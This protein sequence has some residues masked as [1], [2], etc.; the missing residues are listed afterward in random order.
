M[1]IC[2]R[3]CRGLAGSFELLIHLV[4]QRLQQA[5]DSSFLLLSSQV[6]HAQQLPCCFKCIQAV[7]C[8]PTL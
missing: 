2:M 6:L 8:G 7:I 4:L 1:S 3:T 5:G